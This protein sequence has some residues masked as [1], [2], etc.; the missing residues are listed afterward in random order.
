MPEAGKI[1]PSYAEVCDRSNKPG[2]KK[3][4]TDKDRPGLHSPD[5]SGLKPEHAKVRVSKGEPGCTE[6]SASRLGPERD[7]P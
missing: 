3:S 7:T 1:K 6:S 2:C 4:R 5:T